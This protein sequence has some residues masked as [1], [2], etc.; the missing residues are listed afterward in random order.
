VVE[1]VLRGPAVAVRQLEHEPAEVGQRGLDGAV[2]AADVAVEDLHRLFELAR[3]ER[4]LEAGD[5]LVVGL[6]RRGHLFQPRAGLGG[7]EPRSEVG[8]PGVDGFPVAGRLGQLAGLGLLIPPGHE[9]QVGEVVFERGLLQPGQGLE[10]RQ[11]PL[12]QLR[13]S[14]GA[15]LRQLEGRGPERDDE[16]R[17]EHV[18]ERDAEEGA[19]ETQT[20]RMGGRTG[21]GRAGK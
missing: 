15:G 3:L 12:A 11:Q 8:R 18:P 13:A 10:R 14:R 7:I 6:E 4:I 5:G 2:I 20:G 16:R 17:E 1:D 19:F 21:H 9:L